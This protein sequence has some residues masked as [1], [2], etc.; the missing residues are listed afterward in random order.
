[1]HTL[2][3]DQNCNRIE[4]HQDMVLTKS[5]ST[6]NASAKKSTNTPLLWDTFGA[7]KMNRPYHSKRMQKKWHLGKLAMLRWELKNSYK[8]MCSFFCIRVAGGFG[9]L[10]NIKMGEKNSPFFLCHFPL[11][12]KKK[13]T[14]TACFF[15]VLVFP[16]VSRGIL[17]NNNSKRITIK[18]RE[19]LQKKRPKKQNCSFDVVRSCFAIRPESLF[20]ATKKRRK[21]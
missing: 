20:F 17:G 13:K 12:K 16:P 9:W 4:L 1:M 19:K 8:K 18:R 5:N 11:T 3:F 2:K 15:W 14:G 21:K 7:S 10:S 6:E